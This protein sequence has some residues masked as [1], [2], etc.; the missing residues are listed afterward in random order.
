MNK[1]F[2]LVQRIKSCC[3]ER[4]NID[5]LYFGRS[6]DIAFDVYQKEIDKFIAE[7]YQDCTEEEKEE[8]ICNDIDSTQTYWEYCDDDGENIVIMIEELEV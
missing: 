1:R 5:S 7:R 8:R 3:C 4:L 6:Q 2:Y